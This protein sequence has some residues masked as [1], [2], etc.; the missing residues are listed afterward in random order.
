MFITGYFNVSRSSGG[1]GSGPYMGQGHASHQLMS[2]MLLVIFMH[3]T[4]IYDYMFTFTVT[5]N[6]FPI[7]LLAMHTRMPGPYMGN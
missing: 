1:G 2:S 6:K 5:K 7:F 4:H 3:L